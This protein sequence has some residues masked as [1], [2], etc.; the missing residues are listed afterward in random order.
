[1]VS[2]WRSWA[3]GPLT[4]P[5]VPR[6]TYFCVTKM[7]FYCCFCSCGCYCCCYFTTAG[8]TSAIVATDVV[9]FAP[10]A[11]LQLVVFPFAV[12]TTIASVATVPAI[13]LITTDITSANVPYCSVATVML[14]LF[15]V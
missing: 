5:L 10:V 3:L 11:K 15:P 2:D 14:L 8:A 6:V 4:G 12:A 1:M 13:K 9:L 7:H